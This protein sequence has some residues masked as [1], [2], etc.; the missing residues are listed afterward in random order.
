V[1][2]GDSTALEFFTNQRPSGRAV[3][4]CAGRPVTAAAGGRYLALLCTPTAAADAEVELQLWRV[5]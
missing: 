1:P 4:P 2:T 5:R 3:V